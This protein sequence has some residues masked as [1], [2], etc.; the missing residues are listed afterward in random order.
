MTIRPIEDI[1]LNFEGGDRPRSADYIDLIDT[2]A[3]LPS[4]DAFLLN[5][6]TLIVDLQ[7]NVQELRRL[8]Q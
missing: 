5:T 8:H 2:L 3:T 1:I 6:T 7:T 4:N